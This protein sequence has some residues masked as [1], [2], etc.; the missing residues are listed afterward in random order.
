MLF[1]NTRH[2]YTTNGKRKYS[3]DKVTI[4]DTDKNNNIKTNFVPLKHK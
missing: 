2:R 3:D 1:K 4:H